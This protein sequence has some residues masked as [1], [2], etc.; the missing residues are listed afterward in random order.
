M[1]RYLTRNFNKGRTESKINVQTEQPVDTELLK[2]NS[3]S[4]QLKDNY[5]FLQTVL[6]LNSD[7]VFRSFYLGM[8]E[9]CPALI[10]YIENMVDKTMLNNN[11]M[12]PLMF[13]STDTNL[14]PAGKSKY[15]TIINSALAV[16]N[17]TKLQTMDG[18]V[19]AIL[20]GGVVFMAEGLPDAFIID[21]R[22]H[23]QRAI[24][25][26]DNEILVRGPRE[27]FVETLPEN[28]AM[29]RRK[30]KS[31]NL[32]FDLMTLGRVT[33]TDVCVSYIKGIVTPQLVGEVI[34][35]LQR[36]D[37]DGILESG[38][39]EEFIEDDP[40]SPFPQIIHTERP[41]KVSAA[42]LEGRVAILTEGTPFAMLVPGEFVSF[43]TS[44]EDY[45]ERFMLGTAI[46]WIR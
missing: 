2:Q 11:I 8:N 12:K 39:L 20:S 15:E 16:S 33:A 25:Q 42:L 10:I 19:G 40:Y 26:P 41:D 43:L 29:I 13:E 23:N 36:V 22:R 31:P 34:Q 17:V 9:G 45:Y 37:I 32:V 46:R 38:Y 6:G 30:V 27:G 35:R 21:I 4:L 3:V 5:D 1:A 14:K 44:P 28:I 18:I 7:V 24:T